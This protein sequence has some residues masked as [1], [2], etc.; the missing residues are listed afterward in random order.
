MPNDDNKIIVEEVADAIKSGL[1]NEYDDGSWGMEL[2]EDED[3]S[4]VDLPSTPNC[5]IIIVTA[6]KQH[7]RIT[8]EE[9]F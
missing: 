8:V 1:A 6:G 4:Y 7:F 9:V 3:P 5:A 2:A